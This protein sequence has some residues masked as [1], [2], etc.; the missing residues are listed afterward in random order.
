M[1]AKMEGTSLK[2]LLEKPDRRW[3]SAAFSQFH[4]A[5]KITLKAND[6]YDHKTDPDENQ[7]ISGEEENEDL[8]GRLTRQL[9]SGWRDA[10]P[11]K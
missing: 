1:P 9:R 3:K 7:N 8:I 6:L 11:G 5:P 10:R 2:P 4:R